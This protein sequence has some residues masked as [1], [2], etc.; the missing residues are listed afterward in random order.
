MSELQSESTQ[1]EL[2]ALANSLDSWDI[3]IDWGI[4]GGNELR[5]CLGVDEDMFVRT[6]GSAVFDTRGYFLYAAIDEVQK[7]AIHLMRLR[8]LLSG[9]EINPLVDSASRLVVTAILEEAGARERRLTEILLNLVLFSTTN[10][11]VYYHHFLLLEELQDM[12][13]SNIDSEEFFG[14]RS[15]NLDASIKRTMSQLVQ[16]QAGIDF[17]KTWYLDKSAIQIPSNLTDLTKLLKNHVRL[18]NIRFRVK[19][20]L[21][22]MT[23]SEKICFGVTYGE[24]YGRPSEAVHFSSNTKAF[25]L[26]PG[27]DSASVTK[28]GLLIAAVYVESPLF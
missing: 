6:F 15:I 16:E 24:A 3:Y 14:A 27:Q 12:L 5:A 26:S 23:P 19:C 25:R 18:S 13:Y 2:E 11:Q 21:P 7:A 28:I 20:A 4:R 10:E 17:S 9:D 8:E 22:L 1:R